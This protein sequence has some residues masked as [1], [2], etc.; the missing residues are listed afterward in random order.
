MSD[1]IKNN[2]QQKTVNHHTREERKKE[3]RRCRNITF[4]AREEENDKL[5]E[6]FV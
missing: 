6:L 1:Y 3:L 2:E 5:S 4:R